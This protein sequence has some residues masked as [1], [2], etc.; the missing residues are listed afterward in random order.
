MYP[1]P[2]TKTPEPRVR[3]RSAAASAFSASSPL[4]VS[5]RSHLCATPMSALLARSSPAASKPSLPLGASPR[6]RVRHLRAAPDV[7]ACAACSDPPAAAQ[8]SRER[9]ARLP[10]AR[11]KLTAVRAT[12]HP[13]A[14]TPP[15]HVAQA[16]GAGGRLHHDRARATCWTLWSMAAP[17]LDPMS[18]GGARH[19]THP[20]RRSPPGGNTDVELP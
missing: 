12:A 1:A 11:R 20:A 6:R 18:A 5:S 17:P 3:L 19:I 14:V 4:G 7:C 10:A 2:P 9:R 8:T 16:Q 13:S 15:A